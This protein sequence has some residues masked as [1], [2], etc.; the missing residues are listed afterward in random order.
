MSHFISWDILN[1]INLVKRSKVLQFCHV[2]VSWNSNY[3][4]YFVCLR[5]KEQFYP[6]IFSSL[7]INL[8]NMEPN[9]STNI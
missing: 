9:A 7:I 8:Q 3:Y 6:R 4:L 1:R 5:K 2:K